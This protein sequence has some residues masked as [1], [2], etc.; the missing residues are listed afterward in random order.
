M[1][2][3]VVGAL[4]RFTEGVYRMRNT[5]QLRILGDALAYIRAHAAEEFA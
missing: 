5:D 2:A 3:V 4:N 1:S